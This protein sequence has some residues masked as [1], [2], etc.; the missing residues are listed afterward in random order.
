MSR[1]GRRRAGCY[2]L[3]EGERDRC[4]EELEGAALDGGGIG[5]LLYPL[6]A[7][8]DGLTVEGGQVAEQVAV[9]ADGKLAAVALGGVL[10]PGLTGA[11]GRGDRVDGDGDVLIGEG[12][13][14]ECVAQ[15]PGEVGGEHADKDVAAD[16]VFEVVAGGPQV[17]VVGLGDAEVPL[18]IFEVLG[19]DAGA[20]HVDPVAGGLGGDLLLI[21]APGETGAGDVADEMLA[22]L[23]PAD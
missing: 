13:L 20:D 15:V 10:A 22:D 21:A 16:P 19:I 11:S 2:W 1:D 18:D 12:E 4:A 5:E 23:V 7:E 8:G 6:A 3:L 14:G 17:Q 9:F